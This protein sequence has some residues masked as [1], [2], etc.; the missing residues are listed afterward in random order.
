MIIERAGLEVA[1]GYD[2]TALVRLAVAF[3][4]I[5][6]YIYVIETL[7]G[8]ETQRDAPPEKTTKRLPRSLL[9]IFCHG[10]SPERFRVIYKCWKILD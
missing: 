9:E 1:E 5:Y 10:Q 2:D 7:D 3:I 6:I 8:N 4:Y